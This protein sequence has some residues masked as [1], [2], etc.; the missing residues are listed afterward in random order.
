VAPETFF[1]PPAEVRHNLKA[2]D[3]VKLLFFIRDPD[4]QGLEAERMWVDVKSA[5]EGIY[6]GELLNA[7]S[8]IRDLKPG[9]RIV[10][11]PKHVAAIAVSQAEVGFRVDDRAIISRRL[12]AS[13]FRPGRLQR[14]EPTHADDSGWVLL[15]GDETEPNHFDPQNFAA[16]TLG[17]LADRFPE[18]EEVFK[19]GRQGETWEWDETENRYRRVE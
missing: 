8:V 12:A 1:I 7:P 15:V 9:D 6:V 5:D 16:A 19:E 11:E 17:F 4:P 10:F 13:A 18:L 2:G 14:D 3:V